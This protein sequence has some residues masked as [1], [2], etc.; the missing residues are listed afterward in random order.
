M[1]SVLCIVKVTEAIALYWWFQQANQHVHLKNRNITMERIRKITNS[2]KN[3]S[4]KVRI[5][6]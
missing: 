6:H 1:S 2:H 4:T 5:I 3:E